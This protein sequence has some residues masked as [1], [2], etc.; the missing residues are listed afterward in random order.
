MDEE[1]V[2]MIGVKAS[3]ISPPSWDDSKSAE[4]QYL[5]QY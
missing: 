5:S 4:F 2:K 3:E 1:D